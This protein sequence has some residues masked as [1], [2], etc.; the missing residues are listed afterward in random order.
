MRKLSVY[1]VVDEAVHLALRQTEYAGEVCGFRSRDVQLS[2]AQR[3]QTVCCAMPPLVGLKLL[4]SSCD[5]D[6]ELEL[7]VRDVSRAHVYGTGRARV[8]ATLPESHEMPRF[9][10]KDRRTLMPR[11]S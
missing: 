8:D 7:A 4:G 1:F 9:V 6:G 5:V 11:W 3:E 2:Q 10:I